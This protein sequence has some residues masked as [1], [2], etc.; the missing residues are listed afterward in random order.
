MGAVT[1]DGRSVGGGD[2]QLRA[3]RDSIGCATGYHRGLPDAEELEHRDGAERP[4]AAAQS[5]GV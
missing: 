5:E 1:F 4:G 3:R 2:G